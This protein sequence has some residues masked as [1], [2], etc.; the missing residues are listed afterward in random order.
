MGNYYLG[1]K[2]TMRQRRD[3]KERERRSIT[4]N[5][6]SRR[7]TELAGLLGYIYT[8]GYYIHVDGTYLH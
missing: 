3:E 2:R 4:Q 1:K 8:S 5:T 7:C 6:E